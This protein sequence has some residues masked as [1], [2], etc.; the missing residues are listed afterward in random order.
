MK[1]DERPGPVMTED[2]GKDFSTVSVA[3]ATGLFKTLTYKVPERL[4][5]GI[6]LGTR[7][8]VP[9]GRRR[10]TGYVVSTKGGDYEGELKEII[11]ILDDEPVFDAGALDFFR[12]LA[13]Y[14]CAPL[15]EVIRKGLP[16]GINIRSKKWI[17]AL[18]VPDDVSEVDLKI[19]DLSGEGQGISLDTL[20]GKL[21][22]HDINYRISRLEEMGCLVVKEEVESPKTKRGEIRVVSLNDGVI[23]DE[24]KERLSRSMAT[25][26]L[27]EFIAETESVPLSE[28]NERFKGAGDKVK[29]LKELGAVDVS[30]EHRAREIPF[31]ELSGIDVSPIE[32]LSAAQVSA[33]SEM[34][35]ALESGGFSAHLLYGVTG[36]G[37]T[38]VYLRSVKR[39]LGLGRGAIV[40]VPEI[41]L[42]TQL[43]SRFRGR[44][45]DT[46]AVLHSA[47]SDGERLDQWWRIKTGEARVVLGARSAIFAP[48]PDPGIIVVDEEHEGSYKQGDVPRYNARDAAVMLGKIRGAVVLLGSATPSLESYNNATTGRYRLIRLPERIAMD[49]RMPEVEIVDLKEAELVTKSITKRLADEIARTIDSG[50]QVILLLNRRGF[51]SFILCPTCGHNFLCPSCSITMTYHKGTRSLLCHYCDFRKDAPDFCPECEDRRLL[52]VGTGTERIEEELTHIVPGA[53]TIRLDRDSTRK[54]GAIGKN[55]SAFAEGKADILLGTQMVA[56]GHDFPRVALVGA[57]NADVGL[58]IP[59]FRSAERTFSL[60]AQSA[61]RAGR[62]EA[63]AGV[64]IQTYNPEHYAVRCASSHDY[65]SFLEI[66][67]ESRRELGYPPFSR[68]VLLNLRGRDKG[69][70][71]KVS[72]SVGERL[73]A[74]KRSKKLAVSILGPVVSPI[75]RI[76]GEHRFQIMLKGEKRGSITAVLDELLRDEGK[77]IPGG[78]K[79]SVDVDPLDM[80]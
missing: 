60:L 38:E 9:L 25:R 20:K 29:K 71:K 35:G 65:D 67:M 75:P 34:E 8:F 72:E 3:V 52:L 57:I 74:I 39:A 32:E 15:G 47:L 78:V 33:V 14:Y 62:G 53:R 40:L 11:D 23:L 59:D 10:V 51:S 41:A 27:F 70:V 61:G 44:F 64:V 48:M 24:I 42:T 31:V 63:L 56:K 73:D 26:E 68:L 4:R 17:K 58:N 7:V 22:G 36:S 12:F 49:G 66:E 46:V 6:P 1:R 19:L 18:K 50:H 45:G 5:G 80:L 2:A 13:E 69:H 21:K 77:I 55:L 30:T 43:L 37:K 79:L 28:L 16:G 76:K 54:K